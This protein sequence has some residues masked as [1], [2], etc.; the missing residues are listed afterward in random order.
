[1]A[2]AALAAIDLRAVRD[3]GVG[4]LPPAIVTL[5]GK[6]PA[7]HHQEQDTQQP[8]SRLRPDFFTCQISHS[9]VAFPVRSATTRLMLTDRP[10]ALNTQNRKRRS[11]R[12][13]TPENI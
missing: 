12:P 5:R 9:V 1:M 7:S 3:I 13:R 8:S 4:V 11:H 10:V 2:R 6:R